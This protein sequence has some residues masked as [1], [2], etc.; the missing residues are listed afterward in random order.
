MTKCGIFCPENSQSNTSRCQPATL[1]PQHRLHHCCS[2]LESLSSPCASNVQ[3]FVMMTL[4]QLYFT[5]FDARHKDGWTSYAVQ[6]DRR[7]HAVMWTLSLFLIPFS[8]MYNDPRLQPHTGASSEK[9]CWHCFWCDVFFFSMFYHI[10]LTLYANL[11]W[12]KLN[13]F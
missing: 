13:G 1:C 11:L 3:E 4:V 12:L 9:L 5:G 2:E 8:F 7:R 6:R 10:L